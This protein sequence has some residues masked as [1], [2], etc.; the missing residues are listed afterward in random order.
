MF[1]SKSI[2]Y[3]NTYFSQ[4]NAIICKS[5]ISNTNHFCPLSDRQTT[6]SRTIKLQKVVKQPEISIICAALSCLPL[7]VDEH[8]P[9]SVS[10]F[11]MTIRIQ[12]N[13]QEII[14]SKI[15]MKLFLMKVTFGRIE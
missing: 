1:G 5:F 15:N 14:I 6:A 2:V 3:N 7:N 10:I 13:K 12:Y 9:K 11:H 8:I 4:T